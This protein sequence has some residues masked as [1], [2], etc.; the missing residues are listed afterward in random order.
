MHQTYLLLRN[1][2]QSGPFTLD[3]LVQQSLKPFDLVWME[4]RSAGWRYPTE[5]DC[6]KSHVGG[7]IE[8]QSSGLIVGEQSVKTPHSAGPVIP[9][10]SG[11]HSNQPTARHIYVSLPFTSLKQSPKQ[12]MQ[13]IAAEVSPET[14]LELKAEELRKK[15]LSIAEAKQGNQA[16]PDLDIKYSRSLDDIKEEY[17]EWMHHQKKK[18]IKSYKKPMIVAVSVVALVAAYW[19]GSGLTQA[20]TDTAQFQKRALAHTNK[21]IIK[22]AAYQV[23]PSETTVQ[24]QG[25]DQHQTNRNLNKDQRKQINV[26]PI[27][28]YLDSLHTAERTSERKKRDKEEAILVTS[29]VTASD[30]LK[31]GQEKQEGYTQIKND[32]ISGNSSNIAELVQVSESIGDGEKTITLYNNSSTPLNLVAVDIFYYNNRNKLL[33]RKTVYFN[34]VAAN[35]S[36]KLIVPQL[37]KTERMDYQI[38]LIS[39]QGS[40]FYAKH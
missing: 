24:G 13:I 28:A 2:K 40:L 32:D 15:V 4:G 20:R 21:D 7:V 34:K 31:A 36:S 30:K 29:A 11:E 17:S 35:T 3:E 6:L 19:L 8:K 22:T 39:A 38:G 25:A 14:K 27:S 26:D 12:E 5:I 33:Q 9:K 37:R 10:H 16:E 23:T 18:N 1:N